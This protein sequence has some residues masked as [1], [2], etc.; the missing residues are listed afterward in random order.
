MN[1]I[2]EYRYQEDGVL[3]GHLDKPWGFDYL[4]GATYGITG[5]VANSIYHARQD[6]S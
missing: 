4:N 2:L 6:A 5:K 3:K 1:L